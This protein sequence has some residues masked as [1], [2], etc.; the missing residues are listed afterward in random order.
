MSWFINPNN[1][2]I[3][4][5]SY[6]LTNLSIKKIGEPV[7]GFIQFQVPLQLKPLFKESTLIS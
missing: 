3:Q 6:L 5:Y 4:Y 7:T 1:F 2:I